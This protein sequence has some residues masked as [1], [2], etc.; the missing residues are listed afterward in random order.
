[1]GS[2]LP[3]SCSWFRCKLFYLFVIVVVLLLFG[4]FMGSP[5]W[6]AAGAKKL[7]LPAASAW[8]TSDRI[9]SDIQCVNFGKKPVV[10]FFQVIDQQSNLLGERMVEITPGQSSKLELS[11]FTSGSNF[12]FVR[13]ESANRKKKAKLHCETRFLSQPGADSFASQPVEDASRGVGE[14]IATGGVE[15]GSYAFAVYNIGEKPLDANVELI[16]SDGTINREESLTIAALEPGKLLVRPIT[17]AAVSYRV[18]PDKKRRP[19][20]AFVTVNPAGPVSADQFFLSMAKPL[21]SGDSEVKPGAQRKNA[22]ALK[23]A[24]ALPTASYSSTSSYPYAT[25]AS[26]SRTSSASFTP[27]ASPT[28][29]PVVSPTISDSSCSDD[30]NDVDLTMQWEMMAIM[31]GYGNTV[32]SEQLEIYASYITAD[33]ESRASGQAMTLRSTAPGIANGVLS[34]A[35]TA[36]T[37][38]PQSSATPPPQPGTQAKQCLGCIYDKTE[39]QTCAGKGN[40]QC[41]PPACHWTPNDTKGQ[42]SEKSCHSQ[43][44]NLCQYTCAN[45]RGG[46][47]PAFDYCNLNPSGTPQS[48]MIDDLKAN[49]CDGTVLTKYAHSNPDNTGQLIDNVEMC[50]QQNY[51]FYDDMGCLTA[52]NISAVKDQLDA[53]RIKAVKTKKCFNVTIR[54]NQCIVWYYCPVGKPPQ[55]FTTIVQFKVCGDVVTVDVNKCALGAMCGMT[56]KDNPGGPKTTDQVAYCRAADGSIACERCNGTVPNEPKLLV[57]ASTDIAKCEAAHGTVTFVT[58]PPKP[59]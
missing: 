22:A 33:D 56:G 53:L 1:M 48:Q 51:P 16:H 24:A 32:P 17:V 8:L 50:I 35:A 59:K 4:L 45:G 6:G 2:P 12:G 37:A 42:S 39:E 47:K 31:G 44:F 46:S 38:S 25:S 54:A 52:S 11:D 3:S 19:Y 5:F 7:R 10:L 57:W 43:G 40:D 14:G 18:S 34:E 23:A 27:T 30:I 20:S 28:S 13:I 36:D 49:G 15:S 58:P 29:A 26:P 21:G 55:I 9:T 41:S